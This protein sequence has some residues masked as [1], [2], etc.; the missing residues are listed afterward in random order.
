MIIK[1]TKMIKYCL[2]N[3]SYAIS[4][5]YTLYI[6]NIFGNRC[7]LIGDRDVVKAGRQA[8]VQYTLRRCCRYVFLYK[9]NLR[10]EEKVRYTYL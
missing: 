5:C 4:P 8:V 3:Q 1:Q 6:Y 9:I 7:R 2:Y 10:T